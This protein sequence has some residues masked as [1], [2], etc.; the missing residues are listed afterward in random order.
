MYHPVPLFHAFQFACLKADF[1]SPGMINLSNLQD[2]IF[3]LGVLIHFVA[4]YK[5]HVEVIKV[6]CNVDTLKQRVVVFVDQHE[7]WVDFEASVL[8]QGQANLIVLF[9]L[10]V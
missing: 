8:T 4:L 6:S 2:K 3:Q 10:L 1:I 7:I 5:L 9:G